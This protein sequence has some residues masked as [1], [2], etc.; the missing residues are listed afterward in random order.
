M[1][2]KNRLKIPDKGI[3]YAIEV[4]HIG[5]V[6]GYRKEV[7]LF[8][9]DGRWWLHYSKRR[10]TGP[11]DS[12]EKAIQYYEGGGVDDDRRTAKRTKSEDDYC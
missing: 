1:P 12:K 4:Q 5:R 8:E 10:N 6:Y 9:C 7:A 11:F 2:R 3:P